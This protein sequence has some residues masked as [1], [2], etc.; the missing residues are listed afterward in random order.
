MEPMANRLGD[1]DYQQMQQFITD[2]PWDS[3]ATFNGII[4]MMKEEMSSP[5]GIIAI[6]DTGML[7]H[8]SSSVGVGHQY[9]GLIGKLAVCQVATSAL[10]ILPSKI[11]NRDSV[12]WPLGMK[13]FLPRKW[14]DDEAR[15]E[16]AGIPDNIGYKEK[17]RLALD[18]LDNARAHDVPYCVITAD[19]AYGEST[20][21][22][23]ELRARKEPYILG[24]SPKNVSMVL[25]SI[26]LIEPD[27]Q[28]PGTSGRKRTK[29]HLPPG[30]VGKDATEIAKELTEKDWNDICWTEGTKGKLHRKFA[31]REVRV[32]SHG[33]ECTDEVCWLLL[34]Q[35]EDTLKAYFC[36]GFNNPTLEMLVKISR[37]RWPIEQSYREMK[38]ELGLDHFEGRTWK[39]W[40]HHTVLTQ[41]AYAYLAWNRSHCPRE[42]KNK[43]LPT[44]PE[45]RR[46]VVQEIT[47]RLVVQ[48][49]GKDIGP[50]LEKGTKRFSE[51]FARLT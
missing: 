43:P 44:L 35:R 11:R 48:F 4:D 29:L 18:L 1:A 45:T 24:V 51:I 38:D 6:D 36:W 5:E 20:D 41:I 30:V 32:L 27:D 13:L 19:A 9:Y 49:Y 26:K 15:R 17:W 8:G 40:H 34:E 31:M 46:Q 7:K 10:Y 37:L 3:D 23:T 39:G 16:K 42:N 21:F 2:S 47:R 12:T 25:T 22:R 50:E 28:S 33:R 14:I